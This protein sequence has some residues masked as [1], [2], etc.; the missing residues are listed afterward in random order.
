MTNSYRYPASPAQRDDGS[1][2]RFTVAGHEADRTNSPHSRA[3]TNSAA[4]RGLSRAEIRAIVRDL[5]G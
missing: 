2:Q 1:A 4:T 5:L 3:E